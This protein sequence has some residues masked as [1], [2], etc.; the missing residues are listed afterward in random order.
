M[1]FQPASLPLTTALSSSDCFFDISLR[2][3][4]GPHRPVVPIGIKTPSGT[5]QYSRTFLGPTRR[6]AGPKMPLRG[7]DRDSRRRGKSELGLRKQTEPATCLGA[8][9]DSHG[10]QRTGIGELHRDY[11]L[12]GPRRG[13]LRPQAATVPPQ[14]QGEGLLKTSLSVQGLEAWAGLSARKGRFNRDSLVTQ[15]LWRGAR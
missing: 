10:C 11:L 4:I 8:L 2:V 7:I 1:T 5:R 13:H 9:A 12:P 3:S 14:P 6:I 15:R